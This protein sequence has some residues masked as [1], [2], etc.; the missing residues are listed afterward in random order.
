MEC[1]GFK[2]IRIYEIDPANIDPKG[3]ICTKTDVGQPI[4]VGRSEFVTYDDV[5]NAP[6]ATRKL[7]AIAWVLEAI[8]G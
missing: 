6:E 8:G 7:A 3:R 2:E 4:S 5:L 1:L